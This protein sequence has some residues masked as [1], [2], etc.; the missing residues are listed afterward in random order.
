MKRNICAILLIAVLIIPLA[1][2]ARIRPKEN[3][4]S[5][6]GTWTD[7]YGLT[8]YQFQ[9]NGKMKIE[10]LNLGSFKGTYEIDRDQ[11]TIEYRVLVKDIKNTYQMRLDG[12][13]LYLDDQQFTRT[14]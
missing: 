7:S 5:I 13:I 9:S 3:R 12:N 10:A 4:D 11:I 8:K 6:V 2:C 1:G 14:K